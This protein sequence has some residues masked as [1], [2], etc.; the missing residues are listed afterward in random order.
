VLAAPHTGVIGRA[1]VAMVESKLP[2]NAQILDIAC[3]VVGC[4]YHRCSLPLI[5]NDVCFS[6][7][8]ARN[9]ISTNPQMG[10]VLFLCTADELDVIRLNA[11][12]HWKSVAGGD[13]EPLMLDSSWN[14]L[15]AIKR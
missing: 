9:T 10:A 6:K 1:M 2:L 8:A 12:Q 3:G 14:I 15:S 5:S 4:R 7:L 13:N 11:L